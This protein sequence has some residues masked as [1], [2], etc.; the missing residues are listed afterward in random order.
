MSGGM[1]SASTISL[2]A[3]RATSGHLQ[4][5]P[6]FEL[7]QKDVT[8]YLDA[9]GDIDIIYHFASPHRQSITCNC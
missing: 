9:P 8:D 3:H 7:I 4:T 5:D 1:C 6:R 2:P